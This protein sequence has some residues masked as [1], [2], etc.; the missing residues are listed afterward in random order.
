ML[1][2]MTS[3]GT[4]P[5]TSRRIT[6]EI[7]IRGQL[8]ERYAATYLSES[9]GSTVGPA[10]L[11]PGDRTTAIVIEVI[12]Q[13]HLLAILE[14]LRDLSL[15]IERVNPA[16]ESAQHDLRNTDPTPPPAPTYAAG[17]KAN[18]TTPNVGEPRRE[19]AEMFVP[20]EE[21][22]EDGELRVTVLGSGRSVGDRRPILGEHAFRGRQQRARPLRPR[23]RDRLAR[24]PSESAAAGQAPRQDVIHPPHTNHTARG[25]ARN[26]EEAAT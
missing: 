9:L 12:D 17:M 1:V 5:S 21:E 11:E 15:E 18:T 7:V 14:R 8:S 16:H 22:L 6:Y 25:L 20:G 19:Y 24:E 4:A 3:K 23:P 2:V 13:T 26:H 10:H